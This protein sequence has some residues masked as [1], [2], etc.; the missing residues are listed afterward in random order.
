MKRILAA[1]ALL[2]LGFSSHAQTSSQGPEG[3][4]G[5]KTLTFRYQIPDPSNLPIIGFWQTVDG[6]ATA[7]DNDYIPASGTF[8]IAAGELESSLVSVQVVGDRKVE[9]NESFT[10]VA[11][12]VQNAATPPPV[13]LTLLNDD[14][15]ATSV[16]DASVPEGNAGITPMTFVVTLTSQA[17][18]PVQASYATGNGTAVSGEDYQGTQGTLTFPPGVMQQSVTVN[19]LGDTTFEP[20][21]TFTLT[22]TPAGGTASTGTGTIFNDDARM[23]SRIDIAGGA[24]Q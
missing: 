7:A 22:V 2:V 3:D 17:D 12:N 4:E 24:N 11:S 19:V 14:V 18:I 1:A 20:D 6:T 10:I 9:P 8:T 21:E 13:T 5:V 15:A 23:A 16:G